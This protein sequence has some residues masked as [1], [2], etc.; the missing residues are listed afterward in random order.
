MKTVAAT[1][2]LAA[3]LSAGCAVQVGGDGV[4]ADRDQAE[5]ARCEGSRGSGVWIPAAGACIRGGG[6]G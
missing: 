3:A 5:R 4:T 2:L 1:M 6:G